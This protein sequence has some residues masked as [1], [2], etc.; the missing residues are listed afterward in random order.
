MLSLL[1]MLRKKVFS[2]D[3][4]MRS[5]ISS[6]RPLKIVAVLWTTLPKISKWE[7]NKIKKGATKIEETGETTKMATTRTI[8]T[9]DVSTTIVMNE[10]MMAPH[11]ELKRTK[12]SK[13]SKTSPRKTWR[14]SSRRRLTHRGSDFG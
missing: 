11:G 9:P 7:I 3:C 14:R 2:E 4:W 10:S 6:T 1:R 13:S 8:S 5:L 12:W